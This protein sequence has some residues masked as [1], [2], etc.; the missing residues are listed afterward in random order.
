MDWKLKRGKWRPN[1]LKYVQELPAGS[2]EDATRAAFSVL[3]KHRAG[4]GPQGK[5]GGGEPPADVVK[6]ALAAVTVLKVGRR[7][8]VWGQAGSSAAWQPGSIA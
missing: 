1:L 8:G 5:E 3:R 4:G 7:W 6:Q 2:A